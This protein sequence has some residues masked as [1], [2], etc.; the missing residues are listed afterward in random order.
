MT[1]LHCRLPGSQECQIGLR[2]A[3]RDFARLA[4][5]PA[6][7]ACDCHP[8]W[9]APVLT[10]DSNV[11]QPTTRS[12]RSVQQQLFEWKWITQRAPSPCASDAGVDAGP[13]DW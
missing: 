13:S 9:L 8:T 1:I 12:A 4:R 7:L 10:A 11:D 2:R 3:L 5:H 6:R